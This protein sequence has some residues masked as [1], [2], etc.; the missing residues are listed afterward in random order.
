VTAVF[1]EALE[2][3]ETARAA[4]L[5][6]A[7]AGD[8]NLRAEVESL[9]AAHHAAGGFV[10]GSP[11]E[12]LPSSAVAALNASLASGTRLGPY[13]IIEPL[14]SGGMGEL[15]RARDT[16]LGRDVAI[17]VPF[18]TATSD[19]ATRQRFQREARAIATLNHPHI[20]TVH[21]VGSDSGVDYLV[22]ELLQGE[23][24]AARLKRGALPVEEAITHA[25]EIAGALSRAHRD[26]IV[27]RDLKPG[28][29]M[30]TPSGAKVL[31]F[32]LARIT[33]G[34]TDAPSSASGVTVEPLS[35]PGAVL[36]T[37]QYMAPEQLAGRVAD[38]RSDIYAFGA[39][40]FEM[41]TGKRAF[42]DSS[43]NLP[44][45]LDRVVRTC[46]DKDPEARFES[47]RDVTMAL[48]W[49]RDDMR[50][51]TAVDPNSRRR[52]MA[53]VA[54]VAAC[55][56]VAGVASWSMFGRSPTDATT[57]RFSIQ[58]PA[59]PNLN[60]VAIS[61]D[62]QT[63]VF[64]A[65]P[66]GTT[67]MLFVRPIGAL[68]PQTLA[69]TEG[70][71]MPFWSPDSRH[72]GF[73]SNQK[74]KVVAAAG[75][76]PRVVCSV[77]LAG[78]GPGA[79]PLFGASWSRDDVILFSTAAAGPK[80]STEVLL[81]RVPA[82][83][84]VPVPVGALNRAAGET[85]HRW[86]YFLPDGHRFLYLAWSA[87]P[88]K[89]AIF[90]GS[91]DSSDRTRVIPAEAMAMYVPPGY[92]LFTR[93]DQL[94]A[95]RFDSSTLRVTGEPVAVAEG[96]YYGP[97]GRAAFWAS[98]QT[99]VYRTG[100]TGN[101][102]VGT[103]SL[104]W[105]DRNGT[106]SPPFRQ[107]FNASAIRLA[108]DAKQV[109]LVDNGVDT[110]QDIWIYDLERDQ[111]TLLANDRLED[112]FPVWYPNGS[113]IAFDRGPADLSAPHLLYEQRADGA[114]PP[115]V[116]LPPET[117]VSYGPLDW[118]TKHLVYQRS[119]LPNRPKKPGDRR[120]IE[121]W[122]QPMFGDRKPSRYVTGLATNTSAALSP[123][124]RW[125]AYMER[126]SDSRH[127][128]IVGSFPDPSQRFVISPS[129][130]CP[131]W[132]NDG[133]ELYFLGP[134]GALNSVSVTTEGEFAFG[135]AER[136]FAILTLS[137]NPDLVS[138]PACPYDVRPDGQ[139]FIVAQLGGL[140]RD[141]PINVVVNWMADL[142]P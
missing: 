118:T 136:L 25:I 78:A 35:D 135:K 82:A 91:L 86:P 114:A 122:A 84:G 14:S 30:L 63:L 23:T 120:N 133:R 99:L 47:L 48:Q 62:G 31:D 20:C 33:R 139:R 36:G 104:A 50:G 28:N 100:V 90:V 42:E 102:E 39:T 137:F 87:E 132:R 108:P 74:L 95:H 123:N 55:V 115:Q 105:I 58:P 124:G 93:K 13:E 6:I 34:D 103:Y 21:D 80:G 119:Y 38:A 116:L 60:A 43:A 57:M 59:M 83:G 27:H 94:L 1:Q 26:G 8:G 98:S 113:R 40:L 5:D 9:L 72:I 52:A 24:L 11:M 77:N 127:D 49:A 71:I 32:G 141:K 130:V 129:G 109:A 111:K 121:L 65:A 66:L 16:R 101:G 51:S 15:F 89:R 107:T 128:L 106:V 68:Q 3:D 19:R 7:C 140:N 76:E 88:A 37:L 56:L 41:L 75:G 64:S 125:L 81:H 17:K 61:P 22:L 138:G 73:I 79:F 97:Q 4:Y 44:P 46:L 134:D 131:R 70:A 92:L 96:L 67:S 53:L 12:A 112:H 54:T 142:K 110:G 10:A 126:I 85:S 69:G 18:G 117:G 29:V 2:Q 45:S